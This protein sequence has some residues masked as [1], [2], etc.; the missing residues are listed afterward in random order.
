LTVLALALPILQ[1]VVSAE[2]LS[3]NSTARLALDRVA[4]IIAKAHAQPA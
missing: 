3:D 1:E 4:S 2:L